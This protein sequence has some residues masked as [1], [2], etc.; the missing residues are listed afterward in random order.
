G[1]PGG[2]SETVIAAGQRGVWRSTDG[3][4]WAPSSRG[5]TERNVGSLVVIGNPQGTVL[6]SFDDGL[7]RID[8]AGDTWRRLP[9]QAGFEA[10]VLAADP[11]HPGRVYALGDD[12]GVSEDQ[13]KTWTTLSHLPNRGVDLLKVDPVHP[14]VLYA[15]V[16]IEIVSQDY[17]F[18]F[19]SVD[20]G[21]HWREIL[22]DETLID[23][24][25]DPAH[26]NVSFRLRYG[27]L[28]R[29][30]DGGATWTPLPDFGG[31]F[32]GANPTSLLFEPRS[33][34]LYLGTDQ[35]GVFRSTDSGLTFRRVAAGLPRLPGGLN[36]PV[37]SLV[38]DAGG[39]LYT[40]LW[41]AGVYQLRPG[42]GW[43]GVNNGLSL[44]SSPAALIADPEQPG[45]LYAPT[46]G[47]SVLRLED[48]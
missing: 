14:G 46:Y 40:A 6:A 9:R 30:D 16:Q 35:R 21:V 18:T 4:D 10:P 12:F 31:Q 25:F 34:A 28:D 8:R 24:V 32:L 48:R 29:S 42:L 13:G 38:L 27:S 23:V 3:G 33:R 19:R 15:S 45:L 2:P 36:P 39:D 47:A 37:A 43:T 7:M 1:S 20:G 5:I 17:S 26:P 44:A 41:Y 11:H 22:S